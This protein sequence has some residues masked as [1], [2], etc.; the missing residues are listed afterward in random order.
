MVDEVHIF[1]V[2]QMPV[3]QR[4]AVFSYFFCIFFFKDA[5]VLGKVFHRQ[6]SHKSRCIFVLSPQLYLFHHKWRRF[7]VRVF[8]T[9]LGL[10]RGLNSF[11]SSFLAERSVQEIF[12]EKLF[13][14]VKLKLVRLGFRVG[15]KPRITQNR[16]EMLFSFIG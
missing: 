10:L 4:G 9:F 2:H 11:F 12:V 16:K 14:F 1:L 3:F 5:L 13:R 15:I 8:V 6:S 7:M